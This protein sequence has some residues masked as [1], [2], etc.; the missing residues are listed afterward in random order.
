MTKQCSSKQRKRDLILLVSH[1]LTT[2]IK[3]KFNDDILFDWYTSALVVMRGENGELFAWI[4]AIE[5]STE[6][7]YNNTS[8]EKVSIRGKYQC[9]ELI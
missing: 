4:R 5:L 3:A 8:I 2:A 1:L 7:E 6:N 9:V